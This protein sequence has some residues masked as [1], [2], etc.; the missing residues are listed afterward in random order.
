VNPYD[1]TECPLCGCELDLEN[2][3]WKEF[4]GICLE[5]VP[6]GILH[7]VN[8]R[9]GRRGHKRLRPPRDLVRIRWCRACGREL[10]GR[11]RAC[12][13][14]ARR[15]CACGQPI[16]RRRRKCAACAKAAR[17][18]AARASM[19]RRRAREAATNTP[20]P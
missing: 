15:R 9:A 5:C 10:L 2:C 14:C 19:R 8:T 18:E 17:R 13:V 16:A 1:R 4:P 20:K 7:H 11:R 12:P 6:P 3:R